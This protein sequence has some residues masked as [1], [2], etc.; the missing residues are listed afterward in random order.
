[1][2]SPSESSASNVRPPARRKRVVTEAR[3][4]QNRVAQR[5]YRRRQRE[6]RPK[7][8]RPQTSY[9]TPSS[10]PCKSHRT[11]LRTIPFHH[12]LRATLP[13][14]LLPNNPNLLHL[15]DDAALEGL[16]L[17]SLADLHLQPSGDPLN[18]VGIDALFP[19]DF[20]S[21]G[22]NSV[23]D[24]QLQSSSQP[25]LAEG[26]AESDDDIN[27]VAEDDGPAFA[28][29][30]LNRTP[31][32]PSVR[33]YHERGPESLAGGRLAAFDPTSSAAHVA[34]GAV[35]PSSDS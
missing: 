25:L 9:V 29:P 18:I 26:I 24:W 2:E 28:D 1:M 4:E 14:A 5:A 20:D 17:S 30:Y 34:P 23:S 12:H 13:P 6:E 31:F 7:K 21:E 16:S 3:R 33:P 35:P 22:E 32:G 11:L 27:H 8:P 19:F 10:N 15:V